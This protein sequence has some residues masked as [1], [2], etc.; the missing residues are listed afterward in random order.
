MN[1]L[2]LNAEACIRCGR[3]TG[4]CPQQL[5][6]K[7]HDGRVVVLKKA[8]HRCI[9]CGHCVACCPKG[10]LSLNGVEPSTL[11]HVERAPLSELQRE[12]LFKSRRST[13]MYRDEPVPH[14][15]LRQALE[16]A[17]YAPSATNTQ[18]VAWMLIE[19]RDKLRAI[20]ARV[21]AWAANL[22]A[23]YNQIADSFNSGR[24][25]ITRG[26]PALILA[27]TTTASP[28]GTLDCTAAVSYLELALHS[29]DLGSCWA[30]FIIAAASSGT[31]LGLPLPEGRSFRA[32]LML[33]YPASRFVRLPP[34]KPVRLTI[35]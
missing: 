32:G 5:I 12:M 15:L 3:C 10:A 2:E 30:G 31:D 20:G 34:R 28:M 21:A 4:A 8:M 29:L 26:A 14:E 11:A 9:G 7:H 13:R 25:P 35:L 1:T 17:R 16:A 23:P 33:G 6:A 19:G 18:D 24:D 27:H 22:Q